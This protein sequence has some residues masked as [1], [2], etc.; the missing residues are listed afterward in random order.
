[1]TEEMYQAIFKRKSVRKYAAEPLDAAT[2]EKIGSFLKTVEPMLPGIRTEL[3]LLDSEQVKGIFKVSA[4]HFLAIFS[5][6]KSGY[7]V[8]AGFMLQQIDLFLSANGIGSCWQGGPKPVRKISSPEG[9]EYVIM[10][11]FGRPA[12]NV[13]RSSISEFKREPLSES[14]NIKGMDEI[15]EP[16]RLAPSGMNYQSWYFTGGN[17]TIH[18]HCAGSRVMDHLNRINVGIALCHMWL[19]AKHYGKMVE[20]FIDQS[21]AST[22]PKGYSYVASMSLK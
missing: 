17:G 12:E 4:P 20:F 9:M 8:N 1:M 2:Q 7:E 13:H 21:S 14:T 18:A 3:K 11:A 16:G 19:A 22:P 6:E 5:E 10:L 15:L